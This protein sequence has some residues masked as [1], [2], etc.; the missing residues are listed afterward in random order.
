M[1]AGVRDREIAAR[2]GN[3]ID[4]VPVASNT[5]RLERGV[6]IVPR[7]RIPSIAAVRVACRIEPREIGGLVTW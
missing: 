4:L 1:S 3:P 6:L 2:L 7:T 5:C